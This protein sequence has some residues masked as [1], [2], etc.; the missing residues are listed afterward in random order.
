MPSDLLTRALD[1]VTDAV[2]ITDLAAV[3]VYWNAAAEALYGYAAE[4]ACGQNMVDLIDPV[5]VL[6]PGAGG[7]NGGPAA[8]V[9]S[10]WLARHRDGRQI[11]VRGS[12][13]T[14]L[15]ADGTQRYVMGVSRDA[16]ASKAAFRT[17]QILASIVANSTDGIL[18]CD[19]VGAIT[20]VNDRFEELFGWSSAE[21]TGRHVSAFVDAADRAS[22][23][24]L[25]HRVLAGERLAPFVAKRLRRDGT[26]LEVMLA[27]GVIRD[28]YGTI[29]GTSA[30]MRD[31]SVENALRRDI[32]R[33]AEDLRARFEQA[34]TPQ[35]LMDMAGNFVAVN[36]AYCELLGR[37]RD[38]LLQMSRIT[39]T[40][41]SDSGVGDVRVAQLQ[42][43]AR[44]ST[45]FEK[46]LRHRDG[47]AVPALIDVTV[48]HDDDGLPY[49]MA[50]FVR[51][52]RAVS[53]AE[54]RIS[55]QRA[56]FLA[57]NQRASDVAFVADADLTLRYVSPSVADIF[58]YRADEP[59][60]RTSWDFVHPDDQPALTAA[61]DRVIARP[62]GFER[63]TL[64]VADR[65]GEWRWVEKTMTNALADPDIRGLVLNL[66]DV[67]VEIQAKDELRRSEAR[68]RAMAETAQEGIV[69]FDREGAV[70]FLN[71]KLA[72]LLGHTLAG[73]AARDRAPLFDPETAELLRQK[74]LHRWEVGPETYEVP[75][76]HPDGSWHTLSMSV[77]PLPMPETGESGSLAMVS[78]VTQAR[79]AEEKLRHR[80]M[81]DVLTDLPNRALLV[82][83][84]EQ[85]LHRQHPSGGSAA[86]LFL[87]LDHFKLV[88]DS[89]GHDVGDN[90]LIEIGHRLQ[91]AV[92]PEDTVA[93]L[94]GDEFA[95][96]CE[97]VDEELA[98]SIAAR[99]RESL[100]SPV[101]LGGPRVYVDASIGIA[102]SPPHDADSLL[103]FADVAMYAAK[104]SGRGRIR[105][106]DSTL[107]QGAE[108]RLM[109]MNALREA[110][111]D[112]LLD[113]ALPADRRHRRRSDDRGRGAVAL[114][115][116]RA[117]GGLAGGGRR[118][119][120]CDGD[121]AR[122]GPMGDPP[123]LQ[124]DAA[125]AT[126][127]RAGH[128]QT[129][130]QRVR[131]QLR[132]LRPERGRR[133]RRRNRPGGRRQR[134]G[135]GGHRIG[136]HDRRALRDHPAASLK[137]LGVAIAIDDF[138]T[139]YSSLAYL[140]RLPVSVLKIDRSFIDQVSVDADSRA[141][142]TSIVQL[143]DAL[144]LETVAEGIE[145][146]ETRRRHA[147][148]GVHGRAGL[149]VESRRCRRSDSRRSA[150]RSWPGERRDTGTGRRSRT[151]RYMSRSGQRPCPRWISR[152]APG[153][154]RTCDQR[155]RSALLYPLS[156]G[157]GTARVM[158]DRPGPV[159]R[160]GVG[161]GVSPRRS[162]GRSRPARPRRWG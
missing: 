130:G 42:S 8:G 157:G 69:V 162:P 105:V 31:L 150:G 98:L 75:Y 93:R 65:S 147:G 149:P 140:K 106:F 119:R 73:L 44:R 4:E 55:R 111:E 159:Q 46:L 95:V 32:E 83:R 16:S 29:C 115:G 5:P 3:V 138:G 9:E 102:L 142:V 48:L 156:Y 40:H 28:E 35:T 24:G 26:V 94:G 74:L 116:R 22:Q 58:G 6:A 144:G 90:L 50:S 151:G 47:Q 41:V 133:P 70:V 92:R 112:D 27:L 110:L 57:L 124:A 148:S 85:A 39:V 62:D 91:H 143:A 141:I 2:I 66:R 37:T 136:D 152:G 129:R 154:I 120:R 96:L 14:V 109:V 10:E 56:L 38:E 108:R 30:V 114:A 63:I 125:G 59:V 118:R 7:S 107:A 161:P 77:A 36:D 34:G 25:L 79:H 132:G 89:R 53:T 134:S 87:D 104:T 88:N 158:G 13:E 67:T 126:R 99:L 33:Q 80:S 97:N 1:R 64:R 12:T 54:E 127:A 155:V 131:A 86:L 135:P 128:V 122:P 17:E 61:L 49:A 153:R 15:E 68:Y 123:G 76:A 103:R 139:G 19:S 160:P 121:V 72:D 145:T 51:D 20:W 100:S 101:E 81:H 45:S 113:A 137:N 84:I 78:D 82:E 52:L 146:A 43:G 21:L 23:I 18:T 117:G 11:P 60:G 71:Q